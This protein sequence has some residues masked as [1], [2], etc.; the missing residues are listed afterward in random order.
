MSNSQ[1]QS[2]TK[3]ETDATDMELQVQAMDEGL[4]TA[5]ARVD[6][7]LEALDARCSR[8]RRDHDE[9]AVELCLANEKVKRLE[10]KMDE[11]CLIIERLMVRVEGMEGK[12]CQCN[13]ENEEIPQILGSPLTIH[14]DLGSGP[15]GGETFHTPPD[16]SKSSSSGPSTSSLVST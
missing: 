16:S 1:T 15:F 10:E 4:R 14:H 8:R 13:K 11:Q 3:L 12:L 2:L 7:D 5:I 6:Q 9:L